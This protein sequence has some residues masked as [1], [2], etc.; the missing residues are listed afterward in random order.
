[1]T[2]MLQSILSPAT[3]RLGWLEFL[4]S[5]H[6]LLPRQLLP[7]PVYTVHTLRLSMLVINNM[8]TL[9]IEAG[10]SNLP[11]FTIHRHFSLLFN[12][13]SARIL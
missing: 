9:Y 3:G 2:I 5:T 8:I 1:M 4:I 12:L 13:G 7:R 6:Q 10:Q 11:N